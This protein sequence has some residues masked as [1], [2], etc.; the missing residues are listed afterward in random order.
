[1]D[2][3]S[4]LEAGEAEKGVPLPEGDPEAGPLRL[5]MRTGVDMGGKGGR[6]RREGLVVVVAGALW[7]Q[8]AMLAGRTCWGGEGARSMGLVVC[9]LGGDNV[10]SSGR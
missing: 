7:S 4:E 5:G 3:E 1:M 2:G 8:T 6:G 9:C 10:V